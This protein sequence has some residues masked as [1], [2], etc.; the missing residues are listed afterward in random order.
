MQ[1]SEARQGLYTQLYALLDLENFQKEDPPMGFKPKH[2]YHAGETETIHPVEWDVARVGYL[3]EV[4]VTYLT[5][6][7]EK[8]TFREQ[9]PDNR[10]GET[11]E[12]M[13][14]HRSI[15]YPK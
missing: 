15:T 4:R 13:L 8:V 10:V 7:G 14:S 11:V 1:L 12:E 9:V 3:Q 6:K 5:A 2:G